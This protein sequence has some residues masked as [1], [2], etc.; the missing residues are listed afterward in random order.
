MSHKLKETRLEIDLNALAKN[1]QTLHRRLPAE[2]KIMGVVKAYAYG[3]DSVQVAKKLV[4]LGADFIAV[5][6]IEEGIR[7][8]KNNI[9]LPILVFY[10]QPEELTNLIDFNLTPSV[11]NLDF[12]D[13]LNQ[14]LKNQERTDFKIHLKINSGMNRLGFDEHQIPEIIQRL[15]ATKHIQLEGVFSHFAA[16]GNAA[17]KDFTKQQIQLFERVCRQLQ[18]NYKSDFIKHISNSSGIINY[19]EAS[20][21]MVRAGIALYGYGNNATEHQL[22]IPVA[23]LKTRIAQL[24]EIPAGASVG[25]E[26][27]FIAD[28]PRKIATLPLG[29]ADGISRIYGNQKANVWIQGKKAPIVGN[30]CMDTLMVDVTGISCQ[31]GDDVEV[32]GK[33]QS[34][35]EF[36]IYSQ[37]I[38]Y[39]LIT[40][41]SRRV[42]RVFVN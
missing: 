26:R 11:Y 38:P 32:F 37:S 27:E 21:N 36:D 31:V 29:Y 19:P 10:P 17:E 2:T 40:R 41:I 8:R 28:S 15:E 5:A 24:R 7:L 1:Y 20:F 25:Y 34:A 3:T 23:T 30:I 33:H 16:S 6:Y 14:G 35:V 39:E 18:S 22:L 12:F 13:R 42:T 9:N 4:E